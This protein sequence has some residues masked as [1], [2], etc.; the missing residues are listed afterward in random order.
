MFDIHL[1]K[2]RG[3][4]KKKERV[5]SALIDILKGIKEIR[6]RIPNPKI[7]TPISSLLEIK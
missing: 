6:Q 2:R 1:Y 4:P 3:N 5:E 7:I